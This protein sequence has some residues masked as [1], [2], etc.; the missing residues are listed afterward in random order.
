MGK[1]DNIIFMLYNINLSIV[2]NCIPLA[3]IFR[4]IY[5]YFDSL[6]WP[7]GAYLSG[8]GSVLLKDDPP[9]VELT[10]GRGLSPVI[11]VELPVVGKNPGQ[12]YQSL[13]PLVCQN[14]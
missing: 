2:I 5:L 11:S 7:V 12:V 4:F 6:F 10:R 8:D 13:Y 9:G 14:D 3:S 1:C